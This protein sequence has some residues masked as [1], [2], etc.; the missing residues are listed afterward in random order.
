M[1]LFGR[2][3]TR[4]VCPSAKAALSVPPLPTC[5]VH[6]Q[7][8]PTV[9]APLTLFVLATVRSGVPCATT[10]VAAVEEKG[11]AVASTELYPVAGPPGA[12][13]VYVV[14]TCVHDPPPERQR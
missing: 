10:Y 13:R 14:P 2:L 9:V 5:R 6:V 3:S 12:G 11:T 8:L 1:L 4:I 7:P